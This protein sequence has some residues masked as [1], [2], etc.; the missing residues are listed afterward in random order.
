MLRLDTLRG[1]GHC[2]SAR[3]AACYGGVRAATNRPAAAWPA[4][5]TQVAESRFQLNFIE[6]HPHSFRA[7]RVS[8]NIPP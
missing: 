1:I 6:E 8:E 5:S 7:P 2:E 3:E 4:A